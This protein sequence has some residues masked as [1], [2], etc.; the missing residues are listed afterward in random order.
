[1]TTPETG[2]NDLSATAANNQQTS[3]GDAN[4][5]GG[6]PS[7]GNILEQLKHEVSKSVQAATAPLVAEI[8]GL[9]NSQNAQ[10]RVKAKSHTDQAPTNTAQDGEDSDVAK[11]RAELELIK[12]SE[13]KRQEA[14]DQAFVQNALK[15]EIAKHN[16]ANGEL[17]ERLIL[18]DLR[19][20][21]TGAVIHGEGEGA[22]LLSD[23]IAEEMA[24]K[25][26]QPA[27]IGE[28]AN[29]SAGGKQP[30]GIVSGGQVLDAQAIDALPDEEFGK[31]F[32]DVVNKKVD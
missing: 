28:S 17:L 30:D 18:P 6:Q 32:A 9:R 12:Q 29:A 24:N 16:V 15:A 25:V 4:P 14:D 8:E 10:R 7:L 3:T 21:E 5:S 2:S 1:M 31:V 22:K 19:R 11:M 13:A 27:S 23:K 26:F 20:G